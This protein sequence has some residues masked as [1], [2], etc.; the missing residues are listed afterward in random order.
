MLS[1]LIVLCALA[2][3]QAESKSAGTAPAYELKP[4]AT[5]GDVFT[6]KQ[7]V[8][9]NV[10]ATMGGQLVNETIQTDDIEY[11]ATIDNAE[12]DGLVLMV[13]HQYTKHQRQQTSTGM[14]PQPPQNGPGPLQGVTL[15]YRHRDGIYRCDQTGGN[16]GSEEVKI[17]MKP[18]QYILDDEL[19]PLIPISVGR[20]Q[21][22]KDV[23]RLRKAFPEFGETTTFPNPLAITLVKVASVDDGSVAVLKATMTV[24][25]KLPVPGFGDIDLI[26]DT[27]KAIGYNIDEHY[28]QQIVS[29]GTG[30]G[31]LKQA[32]LVIDMKTKHESTT[33][34][35]KGR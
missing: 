11:I 22:V 8:R 35:S 12:E 27:E 3:S 17:L 26:V 4:S 30:G 5:I 18:R 20:T 31:K 9:S 21:T 2:P 28:V 25:T 23:N 10:R 7:Q 19:L 15:Q 29:K 1:C 14:A 34:I 32:G 13:T 6:V 24:K 16:S 33:V